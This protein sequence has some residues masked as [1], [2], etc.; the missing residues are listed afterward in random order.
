MLEYLVIEEFSFVSH[1][2]VKI[3]IKDGEVHYSV[4]F[5]ENCKEIKDAVAN[6]LPERLE[7]MVAAL[8]IKTWKKNYEPDELYM[9]GI[10]WTIKYKERG[11]KVIKCSGENAWPKNWR[12]FLM[13]IKTVTGDLGGLE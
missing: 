5:M 9:D 3:W 12:H 2:K 4:D 6:V 8:Q 1:D 10:S 7:E 13:T 11:E